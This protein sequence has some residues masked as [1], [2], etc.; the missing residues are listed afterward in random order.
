MHI[1]CTEISRLICQSVDWM[2]TREFGSR[3]V[4]QTS[5][6]QVIQKQRACSV[7]KDQSTDVPVSRLMVYPRVW[8]S[9]DMPVSRLVSPSLKLSVDWWLDQS[10]GRLRQVLERVF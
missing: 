7:H 9:T 3:L 1:L 5:R 4:A 10:I 8:Q 6:L 2:S